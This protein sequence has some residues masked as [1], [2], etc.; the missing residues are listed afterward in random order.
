MVKKADKA[1]MIRPSICLLT[2]NSSVAEGVDSAMINSAVIDPTRANDAT[3]MVSQTG[4]SE[5]IAM[6]LALSSI[7]IVSKICWQDVVVDH[8]CI[9][10]KLIVGLYKV[11]AKSF[12]LWYTDS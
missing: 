12:C 9:S 11:L 1:I 4:P 7:V 5:C 2:P 8:E 6:V 3:E 10:G